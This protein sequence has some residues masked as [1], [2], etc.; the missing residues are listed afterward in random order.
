MYVYYVGNAVFI[1]DPLIAIEGEDLEIVCTSNAGG[2]SDFNLRELMPGSQTPVGVETQPRI[3]REEAD[4]NEN[5]TFFTLNDT[6]RS[7]NGR[8]FVC[9]IAELTAQ[10]TVQIYCKLLLNAH[11]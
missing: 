4:S 10:V 8:V 9:A 1:T 7:D 2:A 11:V 3:I 6:M 5:Q